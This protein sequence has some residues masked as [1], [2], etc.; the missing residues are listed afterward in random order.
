[1]PSKGLTLV[2]ITYVLILMLFDVTILSSKLEMLGSTR[3]DASGRQGEL[4]EVFVVLDVCIDC[5]SDDF[6]S[7]RSKL[8]EPLAVFFFVTLRFLL[9]FGHIISALS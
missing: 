5:L 6:R 3:H 2:K 7:L 9:L 1:M 8:F 4:L